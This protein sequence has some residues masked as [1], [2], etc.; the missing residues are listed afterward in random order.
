MSS[1]FPSLDQVAH[2]LT[3]ASLVMMFCSIAASE[4]LLGLALAALLLSREKIR[5]PPFLIPLT[6]FCIGTLI[7]M[8]LSV[9]PAS[10]K[11]QLRKFFLYYG[12][13]L[14]AYSTLRTLG[15]VKA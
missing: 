6:A 2:Y 7:S 3:C 13:P 8:A 14:V 4:I 5:F 1:R 12:V 15:R 11:P 9:D 10:G